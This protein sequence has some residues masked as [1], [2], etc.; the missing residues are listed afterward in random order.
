MINKEEIL[1]EFELLSEENKEL[2][3][4]L[5][6]KLNNSKQTKKMEQEVKKLNYNDLRFTT[7]KWIDRI[8]QE[9]CVQMYNSIGTYITNHSAKTYQENF[10]N[11]MKRYGK[12]RPFLIG[13]ENKILDI[14][15]F[16][17]NKRGMI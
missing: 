4:E 13:N 1:K 8:A 3:H 17:Y 12:E 16:V 14:F 5:I 6:K 11:Y 7:K 2:V 10:E 9:K 15:I